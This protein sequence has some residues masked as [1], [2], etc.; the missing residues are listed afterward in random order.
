MIFYR[1]KKTL[2]PTL[3]VLMTAASI[4]SEGKIVTPPRPLDTQPSS[5]AEFARSQKKLISLTFDDGPHPYFTARLLDT[6]EKHNVPAT[7]FVVGKQSERHP[8][9]LKE[10]DERGFEIGGHTYSHPNL[11]KLPLP[12]VLWELE[13]TRLILKKHLN[14]DSYI[15]RPPG[16]QINSEIK[17]FAAKFGY[18]TV[19]W[20]ILPRDH[21][22]I[23]ADEIFRRVASTSSD[24]GIVLMHSGKEETIKALEKIIPYLKER[25]FVFVKVSEYE[26]NRIN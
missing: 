6:L 3:F 12:Q 5:I 21:E 11:K 13:K 14:K 22:N 4:T 19:L 17:K 24:G 20:D 18:Q 25:G 15:F 16:G 8:E 1:H 2:L 23:G 9:I 7:F 10:I 26:K